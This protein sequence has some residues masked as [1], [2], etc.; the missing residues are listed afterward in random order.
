MCLVGVTVIILVL[1]FSLLRLKD[2][3]FLDFAM[4]E[5]RTRPRSFPSKV[6]VKK[7]VQ[8]LAKSQPPQRSDTSWSVH[9]LARLLEPI[10]EPVERVVRVPKNS[11]GRHCLQTEHEAH[12]GTHSGARY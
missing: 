11:G 3:Q 8:T 10:V 7:Q 4:I 12:P 9:S 1:D 2:T 6:G 5:S